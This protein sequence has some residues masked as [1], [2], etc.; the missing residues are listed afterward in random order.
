MKNKLTILEIAKL[1]NVGKSTVS[2]FL[3][4]GYV[5]SENAEKIDKIIQEYNYKPNVFARGIKAKNNSFIGIVVPCLDSFITSHILMQLDSNL[6]KN[7]Y[8]PLIMNTDHN[9]NLELESFE[10]LMRLRVEGIIFF[11]TIITEK[12]REF[13]NKT[14]IPLLVIGQQY[15][16]VTYITNDDFLAGKKIGEYVGKLG[17]QSVVYLGVSEE[18]K[19]VGVIRKNGVIEGLKNYDCKK[20]ECLETDFSMEKSEEVLEKYLIKNSP[21][22]V[23]C[24]TDNIA[25]GAINAIKKANLSIP[26]D[27]SICGFGGYKMSE[28]LTPPLTTIRF[29]YQKIGNLATNMIIKLIN[30]DEYFEE[31][32]VDF[33]FIEGKSV[34]KLSL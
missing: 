7:G 30:Q 13:F 18:D 2:R 21:T 9:I 27:I 8:V 25:F 28:L 4:G 16:G 24:A 11:S 34:K 10:N 29:N 3:N 17:H 19:A 12:H 33:E 1:A 5:S 15:Q 31:K 26:E 32:L 20:I 14:T 6:R 23:I 22:C